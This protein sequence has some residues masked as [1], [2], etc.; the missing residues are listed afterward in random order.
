MKFDFL[1]QRGR[2]P[3]G[4]DGATVAAAQRHAAGWYLGKG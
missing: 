4:Q 2:A 3:I 1:D